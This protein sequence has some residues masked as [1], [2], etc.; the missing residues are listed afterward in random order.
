M[1]Y[2]P[3]FMDIEEKNGLVVG[4]GR[5]ARRKLEKLVPYGA[6]LT[7]VAPVI[8][9]N[10][11]AFAQEN[12]ICVRNRM[13]EPADLNHM[14]FVIAAS[15]DREVNAGIGRLCK[16]KGILVNVV[17]D[18]GACSFIFPS[19]VKEGKLSIGISTEGASPEIAAS[20][21]SRIA[22]MIPAD[23]EKILDY[24]NGL[25]PLAKEYIRDDTRRAAFLK[26]MAGACMDRNA[27][28][29]EQETMQRLA[30]YTGSIEDGQ[31]A[32]GGTAGEVLLVGAGCGCHDLIT[33][34][35]LC[36]V[37]RARVLVYDD[38][39]DPRLLGYAS[40]SCERIYVGKRSG[41]HSMRQE[42]INALLV[43]K[44]QE[45]GL[46]VRLKGGDPFVFGRGMEELAALREAGI[47]AAYVPGITSGIAV[48]AFAGIPVTHREVSRSFH[49]ITGHTASG[50]TDRDLAQ[51]IDFS[52]LARLEG[53]LVFLMGFLHLA[54]IA[55]EL[56]R[57]GKEASTPAAVIHG[58]FGS[59]VETV[60]G[61]LADIAARAVQAHIQAPAVIVVGRVVDLSLTNV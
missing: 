29:D 19:L 11:A 40:E 32:C 50:N 57:A 16:E 45:G 44:A 48:P 22:C 6:R 36:A 58:G 41:K 1:G 24:L 56:V 17:D 15:D 51:D 4:G 35:G 52:L 46:V 7:V 30:E 47:D 53:T 33:V 55:E 14:D 38:L 25:R 3:F 54:Q 49:V 20:V 61:T 5:V 60:R 2:F 28:F 8:T 10:L 9:E 23:M 34:R 27:V 42:Q 31:Q 37:R 21:R 59:R 43:E 18:R 26:D 12:D 13:F 39:I